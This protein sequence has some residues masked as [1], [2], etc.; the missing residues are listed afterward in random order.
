MLKWPTFITISFCLTHQESKSKMPIL[1]DSSE[2]CNLRVTE[3]INK[4]KIGAVSK[5][6]RLSKWRIFP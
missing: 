3:I 4:Y 2:L 5:N 6:V 1:K